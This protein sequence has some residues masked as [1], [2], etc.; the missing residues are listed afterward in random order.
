MTPIAPTYPE[1]SRLTAMLRTFTLPDAL[2]A[3]T[4]RRYLRSKWVESLTDGLAR[5]PEYQ[6][7]IEAFQTPADL[8]ALVTDDVRANPDTTSAEIASRIGCDLAPV[9]ATLKSLEASGEV[10]AHRAPSKTNRWSA[11]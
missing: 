3:A 7:A 2:K 8:A 9:V 11:K 5:H 6:A 10:V 1:C 4:P